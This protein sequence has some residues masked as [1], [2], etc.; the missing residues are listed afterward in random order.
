MAPSGYETYETLRPLTKKALFVKGEGLCRRIYHAR[1]D[2]DR[3]KQVLLMIGEDVSG[4]EEY[5]TG[6]PQDIPY[7]EGLV[8]L[9]EDM[10]MHVIGEIDQDRRE[11]G[12]DREDEALRADIEAK[13]PSIKAERERQEFNS[14]LWSEK[15]EQ[16]PRVIAIRQKQ[17]NENPNRDSTGILASVDAFMAVK[18]AVL[19]ELEARD[20]KTLQAEWR[21][22]KET[23]PYGGA[24]TYEGA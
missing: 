11:E 13:F 1:K 12:P 24:W 17:D 10:A 18:N 7:E 21:T 5:S 6:M 19:H 2:L 22:W 16:D 20:Q 23:S 3:V 8:I 14:W 4:L 9:T 15:V